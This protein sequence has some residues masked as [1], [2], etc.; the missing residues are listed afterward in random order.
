M[1]Q[2]I[3]EKKMKGWRN[4]MEK[5]QR[6]TPL[7]RVDGFKMNGEESPLEVHY[8]QDKAQNNLGDKAH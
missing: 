3:K 6:I 8:C 5:E 2:I 1:A 7:R 4:I